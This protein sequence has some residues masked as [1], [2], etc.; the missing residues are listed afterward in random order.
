MSE[1]FRSLHKAQKIRKRLGA[2]PDVFDTF[3]PRPKG[4]HHK[5]YERLKQQALETG[6]RSAMLALSRSG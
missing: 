6:S 1:T 3:I 4:M 2:S 5:T